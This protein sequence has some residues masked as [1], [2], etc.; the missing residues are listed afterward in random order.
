MNTSIHPL[1]YILVILLIAAC[2]TVPIIGRTQLMLI[3][4]DKIIGASA[5]T[6]ADFIRGAEQK[7][8]VLSRSES[9][10]ASR[11][12]EQVNRVSIRIIEASGLKDRYNWEV[13]VVKSNT[14][15]AYVLPNGKI[16]I[17]GGLVQLAQNEGQLATVIS[18]EVAHLVARHKAERLSQ[19]LLAE[20]T[21]STVD[22]ALGNSKYRPFI[23]AAL[24]LGIQYAVILPYSREHEYEADHIGL[25]YM[26]K[27]GYE[28]SEAIKFWDRMEKAEGGTSWDFSSTHPAHENRRAQLQAWLPEAM[29]YF[30]DQ[31]RP[32]PSSLSEVEAAVASR[33]EK[34]ALAPEGVRPNFSP[35]FW[36]RVKRTD[37][38]KPTT[39]T[40]KEAIPCVIGECLVIGSDAGYTTLASKEWELVEQ[41]TF[42]SV[43]RF[44]PPLR[45][46]QW[47]LRVG[48]AWSYM[49]TIESSQ[50]AKIPTQVTANVV[51]YESVTV[52]AGTFMA[53][54][55][56]LSLN[57]RRFLESWWAPE[58]RTEVRTIMTDA[59]EGQII[60]E[61]L[62][63]QRS[64]DPAGVF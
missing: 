5:I 58:T 32:L 60:S 23:G 49:T 10:E 48:N 12:L 51:S 42:G 45:A 50:G 28:P 55:T 57:G 2:A 20:I 26:A 27:A 36:Y 39:M 37:R 43:A 56:I 1:F 61:L 35:G 30:A 25:L 47:P 31:S 17:F 13:F 4:D 6:F 44:N 41:R 7:R 34:S 24:G 63:Y 11:I 8:A 29:I 16:V 15:N 40:I 52:P 9:P 18:H 19:L 59:R 33:T 64:D 21:L 3:G 22:L 14:R 62:D 54:R 53:F 38:P 46:Y